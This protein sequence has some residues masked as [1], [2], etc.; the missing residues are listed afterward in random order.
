M[1]KVKLGH[2]TKI[3]TGELNPGVANESEL[4]PISSRIEKLPLTRETCRIRLGDV[5]G[6]E[7]EKNRDGSCTDVYSVTNSLGFV[8]S[9]DYFN[10]EVF[11]SEL[12]NYRVVK[13]GML[14]YNPSRI[15]VG[16]V[17]LQDK[18][19]RV[20]VSPL[21]V[22]FSVDKSRI[23]PDY[24]L[25]F[26]KS[27][28]GLAQITA[29]SI[30][31]VRNNLKFD[32]LC[33]LEIMLPNL[34]TQRYRVRLM[35]KME[36][37]AEL[38]HQQIFFLDNLVKS[39]FTEMLG[40]CGRQKTVRLEELTRRVK[41]GFVGSVGRYYTDDHGVPM[42]RTANITP[43]GLDLSDMK[44]VTREFDS[45]N[46]KS[47]LHSGD[48]VIARHGESG[49]A[50]IYTGPLAQCLN[51]VIIEPDNTSLLSE[52]L[53]HLMNSDYIREQITRK[54]VGTTQKVVN[55]STIAALNVP[56]IP[57]EHQR[58]FTDYASK[59]DKLRLDVQKQIEKIETLKKSLMQ[60]YFG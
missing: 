16:S 42:V 40:F 17:A 59:V 6:A 50:C 11:S 52:C 31:T 35:E 48:V 56:L 28:A 45:M 29:S 38:A 8:P 9:G 25:A 26:L 18:M 2:L 1:N 5:C 39:R 3:R 13:R 57:T 47:R 43:H 21:Y 46:P 53:E 10:K 7:K 34:E 54:L 33:D 15:N 27:D 58:Q 14:A 36:R 30:G 41:V 12:K 44:Y 51:A 19:D 23:L 55:T 20:V 24:L 37:L 49:R 32:R 60:E 22:V 4:S